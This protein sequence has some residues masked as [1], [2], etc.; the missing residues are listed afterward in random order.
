MQSNIYHPKKAHQQRK[1]NRNLSVKW[2]ITNFFPQNS[3][4]TC[5]T[6]SIDHSTHQQLLFLVFSVSR[7][8]L[9]SKTHF[10]ISSLIFLR[11]LLIRRTIWSSC[12]FCIQGALVR[13]YGGKD[14]MS[15][16]TCLAW[17]SEITSLRCIWGADKHCVISQV[18]KPAAWLNQIFYVP[19]HCWF[20]YF[21]KNSW[22][23]K[24]QRN[25]Y[26][27]TLE[28]C[29][30]LGGNI[31]NY[32]FS[33]LCWWCHQKWHITLVR[34]VLSSYPGNLYQKKQ[35]IHV[36]KFALVWKWANMFLMKNNEL[37]VPNVDRNTERRV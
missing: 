28:L 36:V 22:T 35:K 16:Q 31:F 6:G 3:W 18:M 4:R 29:S 25:F 37:V 32:V 15:F 21:G 14:Y 13:K 2:Y 10:L 12:S 30:F 27:V 7:S 9:I 8:V 20:E 23:R 5:H 19:R 17:I 33:N 11:N 34:S 26:R 24:L 1:Y